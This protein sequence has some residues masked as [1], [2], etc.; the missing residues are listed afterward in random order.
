MIIFSVK[1]RKKKKKK[2]KCDQM[3]ASRNAAQDGLGSVCAAECNFLSCQSGVVLLVLSQL[4][5]N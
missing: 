3:L 2:K 4:V 5:V 1:I